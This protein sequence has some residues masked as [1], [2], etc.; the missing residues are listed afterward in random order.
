ME[1]NGEALDCARATASIG[2]ARLAIGLFQ[3]VVAWLLLRLVSPSYYVASAVKQIHAPYWAS[4]HPMVFAS[5][6]LI[7]AYVPLIAIAE[8]GHM[9]RRTLAIYLGLASAIVAALA[10]YDIWRD[11]MQYWGIDPG[12]RVW[13]SF[14]VSFCTSLGL[15]IFKSAARAPRARQHTVDSLRRPL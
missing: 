2:R 3:G 10:A 7:T 12:S 11:P 8:I 14:T 1:N 13:P 5:F 4:E 9:R 15:F 6:A